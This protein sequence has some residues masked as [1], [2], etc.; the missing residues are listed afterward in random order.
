MAGYVGISAGE[1]AR[2][3]EFWAN[4][5]RLEFPPLVGPPEVARGACIAENRNRLTQRALELGADWIFYVDDDQLF[6]PPALKRLLAR[7]VDVVSGLY[8][9]REFPFRPVAFTEPD[10]PVVKGGYNLTLGSLDK[11]ILEVSA[12]GAGALLVRRSVLS[13]LQMPYWTLGQVDP[14]GW[15][16]DFDFCYRVRQAGFAIHVDTDERVGH[17]VQGAVWPRYTTAEGWTTTLVTTDHPI[18]SLP[19]VRVVNGEEILDM[20]GVV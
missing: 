16:D 20:A 4:F 18:C 12:V 6:D 3:S 7:Q 13:A 11:G 8:L 5:L 9:S 2:S 10:E 15:G 17:K 14:A 19:Q 1:H